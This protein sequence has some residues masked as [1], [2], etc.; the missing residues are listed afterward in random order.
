MKIQR[1]VSIFFSPTGGT[2][3][4][5]EAMA[6]AV[7]APAR[8]ELDRTGFDSRWSGAKLGKGDF[9]VIGM[10]VYHGRLPGICAEFFRYIEADG[11]PAAIFVT[12]GGRGCD[13]ALL[14]LRDECARHGFLPV[15]GGCFV[16][17]HSLFE[18][19]SAGRPGP[20]DL[21]EAADF[22]KRAAASAE[23]AEDIGSLSLKV[24]GSFPYR[25]APD[26]PAAPSTDTDKCTRC[27]ICQSGCPVLAINPLDPSETDG[28]RCL[29][30]GRCVKYCPEGARRFAS[31]EMKDAAYAMEVLCPEP[32]ANEVYFA[33]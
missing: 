3:R 33:Q 19:V 24:P 25:P 32:M 14:E 12:C 18:K 27:G 13:D 8:L 26:L 16:S 5:A 4:L 2:G 23:A 22:C 10:P 9:A 31:P 17:Q 21:E 28:W 6:A 29:C 1:T 15:A 30:C 11:V 20:G 7:S